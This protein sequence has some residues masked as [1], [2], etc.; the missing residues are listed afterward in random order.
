MRG[1][2]F[3]SVSSPRAFYP[4]TK[5]F[6][7]IISFVPAIS[8]FRFP[9]CFRFLFF[10][11]LQTKRP[12]FFVL[13]KK[14]QFFFQPPPSPFFRLLLH[15][16][17][18]SGISS[19]TPALLES[20]GAAGSF[21]ERTALDRTSSPSFLSLRKSAAS[22]AE[23]NHPSL[24]ASTCIDSHPSH[25]TMT[26]PR[27]KATREKPLAERRSQTL[28]VKTAASSATAVLGL[29]EV[30]VGDNDAKVDDSALSFALSALPS[31]RGALSVAQV[32][33]LSDL[34]ANPRASLPRNRARNESK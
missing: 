30:E 25:V 12:L 13:K 11:L 29:G 19:S 27:S 26:T 15:P 3:L 28:Q 8:R 34:A 7:F 16:S 33:S 2:S 22:P 1:K 14:N 32:A 5:C 31:S 20:P 10:L 17:R 23:P 24:S 6:R 4:R 21:F 18:S 9:G